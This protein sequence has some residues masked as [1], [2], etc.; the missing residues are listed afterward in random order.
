MRKKFFYL[1]LFLSFPFILQAEEYAKCKVIEILP[2]T[3][4]K[5]FQKNLK[6]I[7]YVKVR[8][9]D[10]KFKNR[11]TFLQNYIWKHPQDIYNISI[12]KN[13]I[14]IGNISEIGNDELTGYV[15]FKH[16]SN[17]II[18]VL[19]LFF[20]FLFFVVRFRAFKII[21]ALLAIYGLLFFVFIPLVK[22]GV[23][24]V[25]LSI[26]IGL[27]GAIITYVLVVNNRL[28]IVAASLGTLAG[29]VVVYLFTFASFKAAH[30]LGLN[31][32]AGRTL[33][34]FTNNLKNFHISNIGDLFISGIIIASLG[35]IM[36]IA[37]DSAAALFEIYRTNRNITFKNLFISGLNV[38]RKITGTMVNTL[39]FASFAGIIIYLID[40]YIMKTPATR[41]TNMEFFIIQLIPVFTTSLGLVVTAP[42]TILL[43]SF[44][45]TNRKHQPVIFILLFLMISTMNYKLY[46]WISPPDK[47]LYRHPITKMYR[48]R[49][50]EKY[51]YG[52]ASK[53]VSKE[54]SYDFEIE[55]IRMKILEGEYK[56]RY[57]NVNNF[58][59]G[60]KN[61]IK[62]RKGDRAVIWLQMKAGKI[63]RAIVVERYRFYTIYY[64]IVFLFILLILFAGWKYGIRIFLS[65]AI[66]I[67][68]FIFFF[69]PAIAY[70]VPVIFATILTNF[71]II[72]IILLLL[73]KD[74]KMF[75]IT[76][77]STFIGGI[78]V[79]FFAFLIGKILYVNGSSI[80]SIQML[81]Y[82]NYNFNHNNI[83]NIGNI[84]YSVVLFGATGALTDVSI[85]LYSSLDE[86]KRINKGASFKEL[87]NSG[88]NIG[89]DITGTM[90]NTLF[91]AYT[92]LNIGMILVWSEGHNSLL[93]IFNLEFLGV[94]FTKAIAGSIGFILTIPVISFITAYSKTLKKGAP[95][96][97]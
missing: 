25:L 46:G 14:I 12:K 3:N 66:S 34:I 38:S 62:I 18:P 53:I 95:S 67:S 59:W 86:I 56:G 80:E 9:L 76:L 29:I 54:K 5:R 47:E 84:I 85:S 33:N 65:L 26:L 74:I 97:N 30:I 69:V 35:A 77:I 49:K 81:N 94:E 36:D 23:S 96:P 63:K 82:F 72:T 8:I 91:L 39:F 52:K 43:G 4:I 28:K 40:F 78:F 6:N 90:A 1:L 21:L 64:L 22:S 16:R 42:L 37:V 13:E 44:I 89:K 55:K 60:N 31:T 73:A 15:A 58:L 51:V 57:V 19:F 2:Y 88:I 45:F 68:V 71:L 27:V 32:Y 20:L 93:Q 10:G 17:R 83:K 11:I 7:E 61:D 24:P 79:Y 75:K 92:G 41:Y 87:F 48:Y 50:R 70:G